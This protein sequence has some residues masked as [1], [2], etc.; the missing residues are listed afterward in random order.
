MQPRPVGVRLETPVLRIELNGVRGKAYWTICA[1]M[2]RLLA[3]RTGQSQDTAQR[4][5][6]SHQP[7]LCFAPV[8]LAAAR[9]LDFYQAVGRRVRCQ[10][11]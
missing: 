3:H 7:M 5:S 11:D 10:T 4:R 6:T 8:D 2:Q 9:R 1:R